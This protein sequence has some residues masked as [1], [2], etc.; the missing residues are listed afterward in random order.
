MPPLHAF[1]DLLVC[2]GAGLGKSWAFVASLQCSHGLCLVLHIKV[3]AGALG[4][5]CT[6]QVLP[7]SRTPTFASASFART[8]FIHVCSNFP[9]L[10]TR[11]GRYSIAFSFLLS[12][13]PSPTSDYVLTVSQKRSCTL[14]H[15]S[16]LILGLSMCGRGWIKCRSLRTRAS[17]APAAV[18]INQMRAE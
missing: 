11:S 9:S 1:R 2:H 8:V 6:G 12:T 17:R 14:R 18:V 16:R 5:S 7:H 15:Y 3:L 4:R 13:F 10:H